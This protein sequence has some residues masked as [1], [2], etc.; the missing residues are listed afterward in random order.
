MSRAF[1][2]VMIVNPYDPSSPFEGERYMRFYR[3]SPAA[4][5]YYAPPA[6][7][8]GYYQQAP[9]YGYYAD[10]PEYPGYS[11]APPGYGSYA[12]TP[13]YGYYAEA[14]A[15][16][17]YSGYGYGQGPAPAA[18]PGD[19]SEFADAPE[20]VVEGPEYADVPEYPEYHGVAP[21][22]PVPEFADPYGYQ[23]YGYQGYGY[24]GYPDDT[25]MGPEDEAMA[26]YV[27][28]SPH[29]N[30]GCL[31]PTNVNGYPDPAEL[32]GYNPPTTVNARCPQFVPQPAT[33]S[34]D[35]FRPLF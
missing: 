19:G 29:Y 25:Y 5:G 15:Y 4:F 8:Y 28:H 12:A 27:R 22:Y 32:S 30:A 21:D 18:Y 33:G 23:G 35:V 20:Y 13:A 2:E 7:A 17:D 24:Q 26:G 1:D 3:S 6:P 16:P 34:S 11:A 10:P 14:P 9:G 31:L